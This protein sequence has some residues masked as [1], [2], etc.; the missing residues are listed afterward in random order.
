[1]ERLYL[2]Q[3]CRKASEPQAQDIK[4]LFYEDSPLAGLLGQFLGDAESLNRDLA[5]TDLTT[6]EGRLK[7]IKIQE[8]IKA[9]HA[10]VDQVLDLIIE[11]GEKNDG[12]DNEPSG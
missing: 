6:E 4:V 1:V 2:E 12:R 7:G 3:V 11:A 5:R 9:R 10:I 8:S